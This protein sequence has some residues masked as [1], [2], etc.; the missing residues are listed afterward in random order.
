MNL[1]ADH[2]KFGTDETLENDAMGAVIQRLRHVYPEYGFHESWNLD[3]SANATGNPLINNP[4]IEQLR[5]AHRIHLAKFGA[6]S[7]K[8]R[9]IPSEMICDHAE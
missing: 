3:A 1:L 8:A 2:C 6:L 4:D 9:P 5:K 7:L